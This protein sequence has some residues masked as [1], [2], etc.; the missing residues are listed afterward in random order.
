[1]GL[2]YERQIRLDRSGWQS[3]CLESGIL[4]LVVHYKELHQMKWRA[5]KHATDTGVYFVSIL[6]LSPTE[7]DWQYTEYDSDGG[8]FSAQ[9]TI[10]KYPRISDCVTHII[11]IPNPVKTLG[12]DTP[13]LMFGGMT[14]HE[15]VMKFVTWQKQQ[16][17]VTL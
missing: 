15:T 2:K 11:T 4:F 13:D 12:E 17:K 6:K 3:N 10:K 1:M 14:I 8:T 9:G 16:E 5:K 7:W